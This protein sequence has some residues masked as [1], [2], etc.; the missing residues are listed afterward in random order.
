LAYLLNLLDYEKT[1]KTIAF[2]KI[3]TH[4][5]QLHIEEF[6]HI[7]KYQL[8]LLFPLV[9]NLEGS[10]CR[11]QVDNLE[12]ILSTF[13]ARVFCT[14]FWHQVTFQLGAKNSYEKHA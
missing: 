6:I 11:S 2:G 12:S 10:Q 7:Q 3:Q 4:N 14:N 9:N 5:L 1:S 8:Q 13:Y